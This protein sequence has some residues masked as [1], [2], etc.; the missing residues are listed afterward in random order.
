M[1]IP[2]QSCNPRSR[3]P[4]KQVRSLS[5]LHVNPNKNN[6]LIPIIL[7]RFTGLPYQVTWTGSTASS[8]SSD[9]ITTSVTQLAKL[10]NPHELYVCS[11]KLQ[12]SCT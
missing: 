8:S 5:L 9:I 1:P 7:H 3:S 6:T 12:P 4:H 2:Y 10:T 11:Q